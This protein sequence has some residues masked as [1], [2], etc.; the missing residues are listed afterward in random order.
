MPK[1]VG[2]TN[3][4]SVLDILKVTY[5]AFQVGL[6]WHNDEHDFCTYQCNMQVCILNEP[7]SQFLN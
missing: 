5:Y 1:S 3:S 7:G 4:A 2:L 6:N